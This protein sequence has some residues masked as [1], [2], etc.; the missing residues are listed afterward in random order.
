MR[1]LTTL[2]SGLAFGEAPRW[3]AGD[4]LYLSDI[5]ANRVLR[6][7]PDNVLETVAEFDGPVSGLGWLP[8]GRLLVVSMHDRRL[9]RRDPDGVFRLHGDLSDIAT[10]HANDMVVA[11]DGAAYVGNFG[12]SLTP[13]DE[14]RAAHLAKVTPAGEVSIAAS[15]LWFPN[16]AV[17]TPD[18][19]QLII[20]ESAARRLSAFAI[21]ADGNL[22]DRREWAPMPDGAFPDGICLDAD[23]AAWVASPA[24]REVLRIAEGGAVLERIE[25]EQMAIAVMLGGEDRK[26]LFVCTAESTEPDF[27]IANRTA[28]LLATEVEVAGAG[29]P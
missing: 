2:Q 9:L 13:R 20:G 26:T 29:R 15:G 27:C 11:A 23:G 6:V 5:H 19:A 18:G 17:I 10:G 12:F 25:T 14:P 28:R 1:R 3:R 4:G 24:S 21:D 16:G 7:S 22:S 8:D